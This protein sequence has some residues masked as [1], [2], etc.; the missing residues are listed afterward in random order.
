MRGFWD[1][2]RDGSAVLINEQLALRE[3][4]HPGDRIDLPGATA[5]EIAG[6]YS[7]YGNPVGQV[8]IAQDHFLR[9][10]PDVEK[11]RFGLRIAPDKAAALAQD[12]RRDFGLPAENIIDQAQ[13][14]SFSLQVFERT[15]TVTSALNV[16]TLSIA[17]I[18]I[19]TSLLTLASLRQPQL[20][21]VWALG[22]TR[23]N[24]AMLEALRALMLALFTIL[25][26]LPLGLLLAWVLL[27]VINVEAFGWRIPMH[28]FPADWA[29]LA[30]LSLLA[31]LLAALWPALK[32]ARTPPSTL[33]KVFANER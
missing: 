16:L 9:L 25:A 26:A 7:D 8:L 30:G 22:L 21:P 4:L 28:L 6:I 19:L 11:R 14:K 31:A 27:S 3:N 12:L 24:L 20:A 13:I 5:V 18:A 2:L 32:L 15:F 23:R 33:L 1:S 29:Y 10:F 17:G